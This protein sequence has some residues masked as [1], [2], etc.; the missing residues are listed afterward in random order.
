MK[1]ERKMNSDFKTDGY[2]PVCL[3]ICEKE[4]KIIG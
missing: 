3:H 2:C 4:T 1:T